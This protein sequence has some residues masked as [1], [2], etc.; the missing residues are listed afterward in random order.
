[1]EKATLFELLT[2]LSTTTWCYHPRMKTH[3]ATNHQKRLKIS[4]LRFEGFITR[5][6]KFS[7]EISHVKVGLK[8]VSDLLCHHC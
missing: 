3:L 7:Q 4:V 2:N 1:M 8:A 6:L 5:A